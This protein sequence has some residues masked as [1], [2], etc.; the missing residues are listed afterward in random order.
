MAA[1]ALGRWK[2]AVDGGP[3]DRVYEA[4]RQLGAKDVHAAQDRGRLQGGL[5]VELGHRGGVVKLDV[6]AQD[7]DRPCERGRFGRQLREPCADGS[8]DSLG[9]DLSHPRR[10]LG[11]RRDPLAL[12]GADQLTHEQRVAAGGGEASC[13]ELRVRLGGEPL[14]HE[15]GDRG[16]A[17]RRRA[18]DEGG[19]VGEQLRERGFLAARI[20]RS[21]AGDDEHR[22]ALEAPHEVGEPAQ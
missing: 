6:V 11:G 13:A 17:Q 12:E 14:A 15:Q 1:L 9:S 3:H 10:L 7:G 4:E 5:A 21:K 16:L 22:K 19:R 2:P 8:H 18:H 20:G